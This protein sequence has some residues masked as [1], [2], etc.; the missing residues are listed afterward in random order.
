MVAVRIKLMVLMAIMVRDR[1]IDT[2]NSN[3][4]MKI[5]HNLKHKLLVDVISGGHEFHCRSTAFTGQYLP[6]YYAVN[7][8]N[9]SSTEL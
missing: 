6:C 4:L 2:L 8:G 9:I 7:F 3:N 1:P 5:L